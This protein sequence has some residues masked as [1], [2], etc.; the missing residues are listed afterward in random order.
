[1]KRNL[2]SGLISF[3][4]L[5]LLTAFTQLLTPALPNLKYTPGATLTSNLDTLCRPGYASSVRNVTT[6]TKTAIWKEYGIALANRPKYVIDH[7]IPLEDGGANV[8][9]NTWPQLKAESR[10]KDSLENKSHKLI[11]QHKLPV[12]YA[13]KSIAKNWYK[14]WVS[15]RKMN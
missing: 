10:I 12:V 3:T 8:L 11:C 4:A 13:Q 2:I 6:A 14:F 7:S 15:I 1:M 9:A 5:I